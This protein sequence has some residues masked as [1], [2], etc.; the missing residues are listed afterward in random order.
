MT[1]SGINIHDEAFAIRHVCISLLSL[2]PNGMHNAAA[3]PKDCYVRNYT[4]YST[5][6]LEMEQWFHRRK[7]L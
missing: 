2:A 6:S 5:E 4:L 7:S 3:S 1:P